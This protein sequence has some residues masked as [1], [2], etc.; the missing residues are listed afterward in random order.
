[1][2]GLTPDERSEILSNFVKIQFKTCADGPTTTPE[3][4]EQVSAEDKAQPAPEALPATTLDFVK[5]RCRT[6]AAGQTIVREGGVSA[7]YCLLLR[8]WMS[9]KNGNPRISAC[10]R[11]EAKETLGR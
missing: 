10:D 2:S 7:T 1:M 6:C 3:S 8:E 11:Y 9:D 4:R 5:T